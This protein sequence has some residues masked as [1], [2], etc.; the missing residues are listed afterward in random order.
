[1]GNSPGSFDE[2]VMLVLVTAVEYDI[3]DGDVSIE[4]AGSG[5]GAQDAFRPDCGQ[6]K[7]CFLM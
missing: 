7:L 1:M 5:G 2:F 3:V 6:L 4:D